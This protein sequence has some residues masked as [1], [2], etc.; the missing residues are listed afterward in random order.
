MSNLCHC[1]SVCVLKVH[2]MRALLYDYCSVFACF[3][4]N[5][6]GLLVNVYPNALNLVWD[7]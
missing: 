4:A 5:L 7:A 6:A 3:G 1:C 2:E